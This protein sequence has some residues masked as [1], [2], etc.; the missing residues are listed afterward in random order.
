M[1][2]VNWGSSN[3]RAQRL[4]ANYMTIAERH[5]GRGAS[6]VEAG[7]FHDVLVEEVGDWIHDGERRVLMSGM[8]GSRYGWKEAPYVS[9]PAGLEEI[10][11]G[12]VAFNSGELNICIVPG[13]VGKDASNTAEVMRGEETEIV[14]CNNLSEHKSIGLPGTHTK[15]VE[16]AGGRIVSFSTYMTGE[17]FHVIRSTTVLARSISVPG[18]DS[19]FDRGVMRTKEQGG[20]LHHLFGVRSMVLTGSLREEAADS[21][22][23]GLLIGHE[24]KDAVREN[25]PVHLVGD[26]R[27]CALYARA[28]FLYDGASTIEPEGAAMRGLVAIATRLPW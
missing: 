17:L 11:N 4:D 6:K 27:L 13:L 15:W 12:V 23:S 5:S 8:I 18:D 26:A 3:F 1:I 24:I 7:L 19:G 10:C 2:I 16:M 9:L 22:L 21:Y 28:I 25:A 14:G 20:L